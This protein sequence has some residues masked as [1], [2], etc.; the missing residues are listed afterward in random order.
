MQG[1][2]GRRNDLGRT[3]I[4]EFPKI[5]DPNIV[6][7]NSRILTI[8]TPKQGTPLISKTPKPQPLID[9]FKE[10]LKDPFKGTPY[11]R[12]PPKC[13]EASVLGF[14]FWAGLRLQT[15]QIPLKGIP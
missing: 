8:R 4:W 15:L 10:P 6:P 5:G 11:F 1:F 14:R 3:A 7:L 13:L 9:P 12:K 2:L